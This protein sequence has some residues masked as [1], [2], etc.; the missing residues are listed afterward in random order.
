MKPFVARNGNRRDQG[1]L[2]REVAIR[3][4]VADPCS[5]GD[6]AKREVPPP[7]LGEDLAGGVQQRAAQ[8]AMVIGRRIWSGDVRQ[9]VLSELTVVT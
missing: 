5:P 7:C 4:G 9:D 1:F 3:R 6:L 2:V 8:V